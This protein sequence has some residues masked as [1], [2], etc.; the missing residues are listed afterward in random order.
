MLRQLEHDVLVVA[1]GLG[2]TGMTNATGLCEQQVQRT[3][4]FVVVAT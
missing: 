2:T 4:T 1:P 3:G